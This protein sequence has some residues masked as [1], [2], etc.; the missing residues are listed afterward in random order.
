MCKSPHQFYR[1][2]TSNGVVGV[3]EEEEGIILRF[4]TMTMYNSGKNKIH[5]PCQLITVGHHRGAWE[6]LK[7]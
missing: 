3:D 4:E 2:I 1:L 5:L 7:F 6:A